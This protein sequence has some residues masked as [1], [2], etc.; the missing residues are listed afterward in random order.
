MTIRAHSGGHSSRKPQGGR[1]TAGRKAAGTALA[2]LAAAASLAVLA[3]PQ[4]AHAQSAAPGAAVVLAPVTVEGRAS[5]EAVARKRLEAIPGGTGLVVEEDLAG[6]ANVTVSDALAGVPG[7]VVQ[8]FFGGNDQPRIQI[9]GSGLQQN[10]V[11]R[12]ILALQNGLPLNR[13]DGSYIVGLANPRQAEI[14]EIYRGYT[15]NRLGASV[16][17]GAINFVSPTGSSAPGFLL[18]VEGGSFGQLNSTAQAGGRAGTLDGL[19][20]LQRSRRD[21]FRDYNSSER[22][23]IDANAGAELTENVTTRFFAGYTDLSFD[24]AGPLTKSLLKS[25]PERVFT[26]PTL[27]NGVATNPG[28]NVVRDRPR[29]EAR[30]FRVGNRTTATFGP[31]LIDLALGYTHTDDTFRFPISSGIRKTEGGD[32]TAVARYAYSPDPSQPLPL[33]ETTLRYV[34]GSADRED[35]LN[36][37]GRQGALFGRSR[38][39]AT[40]LAIHSGLNLPVGADVTLSPGLTIAH[41]TRKNEDRF[42]AAR[43]PT[44]AFNPANPSVALPAGSIPAGNTSYDRGYDGFSPSLGVSWKPL[45]DHTLFAAVSRSFE[46]PTHDDLIATVNGTPNSSAGRPNPPQ[47]AFVSS[48]FRTPDLKA[49]TATTV[50]AGWR[51]RLGPL[52]VDAGTYYSWVRN[53]LLSLRDVTGASLGAVN[54]DETRHLGA[55]LGLS[56]SLTDSLS[57]RVAYS[58]QDF[59]F[60]D[61]PVRGDNRL[62]GAPRHV[63]NATARYAI[64]PA[65]A[66]QAE[67][68]WYPGKTPVDNMNSVYTDGYATVDLRATYD[69]TDH[70]SVYGEARN[71]FDKTYASSTLIVDQASPTQAVYLPGDG[72]AIYAGLKARF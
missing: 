51:G 3:P 23:G 36:N 62:A 19:I 18:G 44:I 2:G 70:V 12:G 31:H 42:G 64:T 21:G 11:E 60:H 48:A 53:E 9:R 5:A 30:Q 49:Q 58:F 24:V 22:T 67:V 46:P 13:A 71:I 57:G 59:R 41:A 43:R 1:T 4:A 47:P 26:G 55:E 37:A 28:P 65:L 54:A 39:D 15:A 27:V 33:F 25:N 6:K 63:I 68:D 7:V 52:A 34:V 35:Y 10:P 72:R 56:A 14:T 45:P 32:V 29:R 20:Q 61:D 66:V 50:E 8:N 40:T 17:G 38:L 69:V 16:L